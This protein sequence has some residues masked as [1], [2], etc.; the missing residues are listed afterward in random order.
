MH[1]CNTSS[2]RL[3]GH[4]TQQRAKYSTIRNP[5]QR[6][7]KHQV[8]E[9]P[10]CVEEELI[11]FSDR[12]DEFLCSEI[13][14]QA[15]SF[16]IITAVVG[17]AL[18]SWL[19]ISN[20]V[21][22][23]SELLD[24]RLAE[25]RVVTKR[26]AGNGDSGYSP[27]GF[28]APRIRSADSDEFRRERPAWKDL[29]VVAKVEESSEEKSKPD[30]T[31][32]IAK[33]STG[34][35]PGYKATKRTP[36]K[37]LSRPK[38]TTK[39]R[40]SDQDLDRLLFPIV[41][42]RPGRSS[43]QDVESKVRGNL[44]SMSDSRERFQVGLVLDSRGRAIV[45]SSF[46][47]SDYL[48]RMW[49]KGKLR[50]GRL[51]AEDREFGIALISVSGGDFKDLPLAPAPPLPGE[52]LLGFASRGRGALAKRLYGGFSFGKAGFFLDGDL[53][54]SSLGTS[55]LNERGEVVGAHFDELPGAPGRGFHLACDSSV[56]H[57]LLRGYR[58]GG[59]QGGTVSDAVN[60]LASFLADIESVGEARR[61][62]ILPGIGLSDFHLGARD[63]EAKNWASDPDV[64][65]FGNGIERWDCPAPP[66]SL[67]FVKGRLAIAATEHSGFSTTN[68]LAV[69]AEANYRELVK[70]QPSLEK[71]GDLLTASGLEIALDS[72]SRVASFVV[73]PEVAK[74]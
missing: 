14:Q 9:E 52:P 65:K 15:L 25:G 11:D 48:N 47:R 43:L 19:F 4:R 36:V 46:A 59:S 57:R 56:I 13:K 51:L 30:K 32:K 35:V 39:V 18:S 10:L 28:R 23:A 74:R 70:K 66:V 24:R 3:R 7:G 41:A 53:D 55:L 31:R 72:D 29:P 61:G 2:H 12:D 5:T 8:F 42:S 49:A 27:A 60:Q 16:A 71:S 26:S 50:Q 17:F 73:K 37:R 21:G 22:P 40:K 58:G 62:R 54:G 38:K 63:T 69:G 45:S 34:V 20:K 1:R 6:P 67:Y 64:K 68:G 33:T 44:L